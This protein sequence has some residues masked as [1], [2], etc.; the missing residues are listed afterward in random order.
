ML[1][2][3]IITAIILALVFLGVLFYTPWQGF[4]IFTGLVFVLAT[5]EWANLAG[6]SNNAARL[7]YTLVTVVVA[8]AIAAHNNWFFEEGYLK[9]I[10]LLAGMW[11][12]LA[13]LWVQGYPSSAIL[14]GSRAVRLLMGWF[15][16]VPAWYVCLYLNN[17]QD[18]ETSILILVLIVAAAD[19]G[20]YFA[21]RAFGQHKL[22]PMVS[23]GKTW[24]GVIGGLVAN[25][26]LV[27]ML[28]LLLHIPARQLLAF[29]IVILPAALVSVLG[30]LLESMVKRHRGIK[31][32]SSL[33][34]GHGGI[35][36]RIDGLL[37]AAPVFL[38]SMM[39]IGWH[40]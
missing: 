13:L 34:P 15:V 22:A 7:A 23:P 24:E 3:R 40:R 31:D 36:D 5:W 20:A 28:M 4:A 6:V 26:L 16:L 35:L 17:L 19:I 8:L 33:L 39:L 29:A 38:L 2:V 12:A 9:R 18:G 27:A 32:S 30:D 14:W 21:G 10:L 37:A 1:K 11:W 25:C